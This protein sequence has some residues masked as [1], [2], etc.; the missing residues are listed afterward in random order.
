MTA[1]KEKIKGIIFDL[2]FSFDQIKDSSKGLSFNDKGKLNMKMGC[3]KFSAQDIVQNLSANN[4]EKIFK[5]CSK[6]DRGYLRR[7]NK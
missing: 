5:Y 1:V 6:K 7:K 4:L 2:G 3:N